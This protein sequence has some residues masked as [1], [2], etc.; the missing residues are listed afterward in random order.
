MKPTSEQSQFTYEPM[1]SMMEVRAAIRKCE[2][3]HVQQIAY[4]SYMDT[5]TQVCFTCQKIRSSIGWSG[6]RS[7]NLETSKDVVNGQAQ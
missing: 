3:R 5:L 7:W 1:S 4:S 2:G 6:N